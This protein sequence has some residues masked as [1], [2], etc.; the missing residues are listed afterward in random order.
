[1]LITEFDQTFRIIG[2]QDRGMAQIGSFNYNK[3]NTRTFIS[4]KNG[5]DMQKDFSSHAS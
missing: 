3:K 4:T 2:W 1:M 5:L